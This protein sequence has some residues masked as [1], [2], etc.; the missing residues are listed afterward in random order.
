MIYCDI[1]YENKYNYEKKEVGVFNHEEFY[2][3]VEE[4]KNKYD[5]Y[6]SEYKE[7]LRKGFKVVWETKSRTGLKNENGKAIDTREILITP[8]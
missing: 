3:W 8:V 7:N 1:P 5:I 2:K 6:I 4:N